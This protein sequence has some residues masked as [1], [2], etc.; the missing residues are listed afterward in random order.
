MDRKKIVLED[1]SIYLLSRRLYIR[2]QISDRSYTKHDL[3]ARISRDAMV[4]FAYIRDRDT[5]ID[6]IKLGAKHRGSLFASMRVSV[7]VCM[8]LSDG[9]RV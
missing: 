5:P 6:I 3:F 7:C 8:S 2:N 9:R 1:I 4:I